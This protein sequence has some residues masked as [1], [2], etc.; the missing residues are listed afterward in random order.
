[1]ASQA[2]RKSP[3]P[4]L[5]SVQGTCTLEWRC[6]LGGQGSWACWERSEVGVCD[7]LTPPRGTH[8]QGWSLLDLNCKSSESCRLGPELGL[9]ATEWGP[10]PDSGLFLP[11]EEEG[12]TASIC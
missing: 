8:G 2:M 5:P 4:S 3:G 10:R 12:A 9:Q 1:M 11:Q 7:P 6:K